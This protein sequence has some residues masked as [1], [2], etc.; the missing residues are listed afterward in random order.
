M[1]KEERR[2]DASSML[3]SGLT[4]LAPILLESDA[5]PNMRRTHVNLK[6]HISVH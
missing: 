5:R 6:V 1:S 3:S 4:T 2:A